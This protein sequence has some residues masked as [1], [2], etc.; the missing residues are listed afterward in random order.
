MLKHLMLKTLAISFLMT[1]L[2]HADEFPSRALKITQ[3]RIVETVIAG[4]DS[5]QV[6][7]NGSG[8]IWFTGKKV[9]MQSTPSVI[10]D[11]DTR[12]IEMEMPAPRAVIMHSHIDSFALAMNLA[13]AQSWEKLQ[14]QLHTEMDLP[15][16]SSNPANAMFTLLDR[17]KEAAESSDEKAIGTGLAKYFESVDFGLKFTGD[18]MKI[19]GFMCG[20]YTYSTNFLGVNGWGEVWTTRDVPAECGEFEKVEKMVNQMSP[21]KAVWEDQKLDLPGTIV[22]LVEWG[23]IAGTRTRKIVELQRVEFDS[24]LTA[25]VT[26]TEGVQRVDFLA[27]TRMTMN[28]LREQLQKK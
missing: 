23:D 11:I 21:S 26:L 24:L 3:T 4:T 8:V 22:R 14:K 1:C 6:I 17:L 27:V 19:N 16:D 13:F 5:N 10:F 28:A 25:P 12:M 7:E 18:S 15:T 20:K 2:A 9:Y